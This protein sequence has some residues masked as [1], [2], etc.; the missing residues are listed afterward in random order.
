MRAIPLVILLSLVLPALAADGSDLLEL[1]P[2][3]GG[4][5]LETPSGQQFEQDS[6]AS[7]LALKAADNDLQVR[8]V[9]QPDGRYIQVLQQTFLKERGVISGVTPFALPTT[10]PKILSDPVLALNLRRMFELQAANFVDGKLVS[11]NPRVI[12]GVAIPSATDTVAIVEG[13]GNAIQGMCSGAIIGNVPGGTAILTASHCVCEMPHPTVRVGQFVSEHMPYTAYLVTQKVLFD[14]SC[15]IRGAHE[16]DQDYEW[17]VQKA[18]AGRDL[19]VMVTD[20]TIPLRLGTSRPVLNARRFANW[21]TANHVAG[22]DFFVRVIGY[23]YTTITNGSPSDWA[24]RMFADIAVASAHCDAAAA[25]ANNCAPNGPL[26][27]LVTMGNSS[28]QLSEGPDGQRK[29][30]VYTCGGDSGG[31]VLA[32]V[33]ENGRV[34]YYLVGVT[35]RGTTDACGA[36]GIY[37][38]VTSD[39]VTTWLHDKFGASIKS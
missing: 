21:V 19:A 38:I 13:S 33:V 20:Q 39:R 35:S 17:D 10:D 2:F 34:S 18:M 8:H 12:G 28:H 23:G 32:D 30:D 6:V 3:P 31:P 1:N 9:A 15:P 5:G 24:Q 4:R 7:A 26:D 27:E 11:S 25:A 36:G 37:S 29:H 14:G 22:G 16:A